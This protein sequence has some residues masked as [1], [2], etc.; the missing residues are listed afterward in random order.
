MYENS[1]GLQFQNKTNVGAFSGMFSGFNN[2]SLIFNNNVCLFVCL[3]VVFVYLSVVFASC[4][5]FKN[6]I[7]CLL[8]VLCA[9]YALP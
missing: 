6:A 5:F 3:F 1:K 4:D 7:V 2:C 9:L 8:H